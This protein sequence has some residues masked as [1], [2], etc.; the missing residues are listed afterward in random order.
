MLQRKAVRRS[1]LRLL[2]DA[3]GDPRGCGPFSVADTMILQSVFGVPLDRQGPER[4][5]V[6]GLFTFE[7][8]SIVCVAFLAQL[9]D[10]S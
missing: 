2:W 10:L 5:V 9:T 8:L 3:E 1:V 7:T 4:K 6:N